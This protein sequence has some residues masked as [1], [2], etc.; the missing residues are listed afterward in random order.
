MDQ[1]PDA[2]ERRRLSMRLRE[3]AARGANAALN[4]EP[5]ISLEGRGQGRG[6]PVLEG[7]AFRH[8][9]A[10]YNAAKDRLS[11]ASEMSRK[12]A[13]ATRMSDHNRYHAAAMASYAAAME[14]NK[15]I[16]YQEGSTNNP[17][18]KK[19]SDQAKKLVDKAYDMEK[20]ERT[21]D[22]HQSRA[23][24]LAPWRDKMLSKGQGGAAGADALIALHLEAAD[25][26]ANN[27]RGSADLSERAYRA[28]RE[29]VG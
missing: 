5:R 22:W 18:A 1:K 2:R 26:L 10:A 25:A 23:A 24:H 29:M 27:R 20:S 15:G 3:K 21:A 19:L 9:Y 16:G 8:S 11:D 14:H 28:D 12:A 13:T 4:T 17:R 6:G 7:L